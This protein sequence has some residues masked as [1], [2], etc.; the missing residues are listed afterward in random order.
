SLILALGCSLVGTG[1]FYTRVKDRAYFSYCYCGA[2]EVDARTVLEHADRLARLNGLDSPRFFLPWKHSADPRV[3]SVQ[4]HSKDT[5]FLVSVAFKDAIE[6][7]LE[8]HAG[9]TPKSWTKI[10]KSIEDFQRENWTLKQ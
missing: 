6:V 8:I 3:W 9:R 2:T 7:V 1:C 5:P 10:T 4:G